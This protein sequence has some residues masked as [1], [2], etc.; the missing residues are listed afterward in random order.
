MILLILSTLLFIL[1]SM[2]INLSGNF[3]T[4]LND[5][6]YTT[7]DVLLVIITTLLFSVS[8]NSQPTIDQI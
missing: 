5:N 3:V 8:R 7:I 6:S 1:N 4:F 2:F